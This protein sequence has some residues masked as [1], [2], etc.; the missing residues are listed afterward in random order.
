MPTHAFRRVALAAVLALL[1]A[2]PARAQ[3]PTARPVVVFAAASLKNALDAAVADWTATTGRRVTVAYAASSALARQIE[4]G[5]PADVYISADLDWM[6]WAAERELVKPGTRR[7]LLANTLVLVAPAD[8]PTAFKLAKGADLGAVLGTGRLAIGQVQSV[9][10]GKYAKDA[11][12]ALGLWSG[13]A[14]R[15]AQVDSVRAALALVARGEVPFAIVYATD[16]RAEPRVKVLDTFPAGSHA[17]VVYPAA[18]TAASS[19]PDAGLFLD[20][21]RSPAGTAIF[22]RHGFSV[23]RG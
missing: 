23:P 3:P 4:Q 14:A 16:A 11:L 9:P 8:S 5:A 15:L 22:A 6:N 19:N 10:A 12:E 20:H 18:V 2:V 21:L 7:V 17:P 1:A 13:V